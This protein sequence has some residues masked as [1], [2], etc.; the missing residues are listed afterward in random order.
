MLN[1]AVLH[2]KLRFISYEENEKKDFIHDLELL[3]FASKN[4]SVETALF[5]RM[6]YRS[7]Y[8]YFKNQ[9]EENRY[10]REKAKKEV[11]RFRYLHKNK[12]VSLSELEYKELELARLEIQRDMLIEQHNAKWNKDLLSNRFKLKELGTQREQIEKDN[13]LRTI[14]SPIA[15]TVEQFSGISVGS[16]VQAGQLLAVISPDKDLIAEIYVLPRDIGLLRIDTKTKIQVDAFNYNQWGFIN[17]VVKQISDDF[18]L[19]DNKPLFR[20]RCRLDRTFLQLKN[21]YKGYLKKGMTFQARFLITQRTLFQL[22]YDKVDNW[23]NP[24]SNKK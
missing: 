1:S 11:D 23:L 5:K 18:I 7:E 16:Y 2:E 13:E 3:T 20:V 8:F 21:G 14:K 19:V 15:G 22:L 12:L 6:H 9:I 10:S 17:G 4:L 24:L